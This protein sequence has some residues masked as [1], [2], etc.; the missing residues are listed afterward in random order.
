MMD[1]HEDRRFGDWFLLICVA[2]VVLAVVLF[3]K[4]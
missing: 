4:G 2:I 3:A 1:E